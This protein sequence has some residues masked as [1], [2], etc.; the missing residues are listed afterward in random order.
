MRD[1]V[2][3]VPSIKWGNDSLRSRCLD[4]RDCVLHGGA[5][6]PNGSSLRSKIRLNNM[7]E[8]AFL[9]LKTDIFIL[10]AHV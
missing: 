8:H 5:R 4:I 9:Q 6:L 2:T 10:V 7:F 1:T 3:G